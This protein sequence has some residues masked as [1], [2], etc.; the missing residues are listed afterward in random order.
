VLPA[1]DPAGVV[2]ID[3]A[4]ELLRMS[5]FGRRN[6]LQAPVIAVVVTD[7]GGTSAV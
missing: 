1:S 6:E 7:S 5:L 3:R 2:A 4:S